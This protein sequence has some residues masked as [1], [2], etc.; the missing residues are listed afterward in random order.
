MSED[1]AMVDL[2]CRRTDPDLAKGTVLWRIFRRL[3]TSIFG[4]VFCDDLADGAVAFF[5]IRTAFSFGPV[6]C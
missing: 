3:E 4:T 6:R 5:V 1:T 2:H